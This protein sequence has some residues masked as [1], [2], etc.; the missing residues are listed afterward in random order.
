M[1][2]PPIWP[3]PCVGVNEPCGSS[4]TRT[5]PL[6]WLDGWQTSFPVSRACTITTLSA[7]RIHSFSIGHGVWNS[8]RRS[9]PIATLFYDDLD[10]EE[11]AAKPL[12]AILKLVRLAIF[13]RS[14]YPQVGLGEVGLCCF[15]RLT[16]RSSIASSNGPREQR[17]PS[18][19]RVARLQ[20]LSALIFDLPTPGPGPPGGRQMRGSF[21]SRPE[22]RLHAARRAG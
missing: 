14:R 2:S 10:F 18:C 22:P 7:R 6:S 17:N 19:R 3:M 20:D 21:G 13:G 12:A 9:V 11:P 4:L 1:L 5:C 16:V 15:G 8:P